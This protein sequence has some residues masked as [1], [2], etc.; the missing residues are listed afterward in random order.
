V[1]VTHEVTVEVAYEDALLRLIH[2]I[3][4]GSLHS[5]SES[6]Y[7]GGLD[8]LVRVGPLG[9]LPGLSK[10][11]RVRALVPDRHGATTTVSLRWEATGV[12]GDLFPALDADLILL[13]DGDARCRLR[14]LG[15]YRPP[16]GWAGVALDWAVLG[17][18]ATATVRTLVERIAAVVLVPAPQVNLSGSPA[19]SFESDA[20]PDTP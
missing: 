8:L 5:I 12:A 6:S 2:L 3:N 11:V 13:G 19:V 1:F 9:D 4:R 15:S 18:V 7:E 10:L 20:Q 17:R 16:L 14:L